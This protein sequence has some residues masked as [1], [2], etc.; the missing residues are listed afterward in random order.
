MDSWSDYFHRQST[1][2]LT[3]LAEE[4]CLYDH[5]L[6]CV[7]AELPEELLVR[8]RAL[9]VNA[10]GYSDQ[11]V[12]R[13]MERIVQAPLIERDFKFILNRCCHILIN[14]WLMQPRQHYAI[15]LLVNLLTTIPDS[16]G[17]NRTTKRLRQFGR[18]FQQSEQFAA[19][20]RL[21]E[22]VNHSADG[23]IGSETKPL[24]SLIRRYP[25]LYEHNLLTVDSTDEERHR[26][27]RMQRQVQQQFE[28]DLARYATYKVQL[29]SRS[30]PVTPLSQG[31][32]NQNPTL[33]SDRKL[34]K[35]LRQFGGKIDGHN[36]YRDM[37]QRFLTYSKHSPCY[38]HFKKDLY[39]YL[40][41]SVDPRYGHRQFNP[42][43]AD[44][45]QATLSDQ[46]DQPLNDV[47]LVGTCRRLLNFLVVE[48]QQHL[49]HVVFVD[50]LGNLGISM[51]IGL[52]LKVLLIC[53][54]VKP[55]LEKQFALLFQHYEAS[56]REGVLWLVESLEHLNV[57]LS[58]NFGSLKLC[59]A[60]L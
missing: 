60:S 43:L 59:S 56:A 29:C 22:L 6:I 49:N 4:Q 2:H 7:R 11:Q 44:Y 10:I 50:L 46:D 37:A 57:A 23:S 3:T 54:T 34:D 21:S 52:L 31:R 36:T 51:T 28:Q 20:K 41:A 35:A 8:F 5:L 32:S 38:R 40:T 30:S 15:P 17:Q 47:L 42:R 53:R 27:R 18:T 19:L 39:D 16:P 26:I 45:L 12:W 48:N 33:L 55:Y 24:G 1:G 13:A 25:C 9:F 14:H 58:V